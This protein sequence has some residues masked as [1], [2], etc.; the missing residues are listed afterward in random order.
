MYHFVGVA[1]RGRVR[2][3]VGDGVCGGGVVAEGLLAAARDEIPTQQ[4]FSGS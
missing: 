3:D 4:R 1:L 2:E